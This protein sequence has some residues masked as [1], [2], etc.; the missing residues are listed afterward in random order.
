MNFPTFDLTLSAS[1]LQLES[2]TIAL[3]RIGDIRTN[4][5]TEKSK[6][7]DT[8][9]QVFHT[10]HPSSILSFDVLHALIARLQQSK[11]ARA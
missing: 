11:R 4:L 8:D 6:I 10:V 3:E 7:L 1:Q 5:W 2:K 9:G